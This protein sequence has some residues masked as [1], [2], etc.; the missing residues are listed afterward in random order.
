M[1][2]SLEDI[3]AILVAVAICG[4]VAYEVRAP[5]WM[6][7]TK[8]FRGISPKIRKPIEEIATRIYDDTRSTKEGLGKLFYP[9]YPY[10]PLVAAY[11]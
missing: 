3:I 4:S 7:A 10:N 6:A 11:S 5:I 2:I 9:D 1:G 8:V